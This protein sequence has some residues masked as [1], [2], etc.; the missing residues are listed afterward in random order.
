MSYK[1]DINSDDS[2]KNIDS[3]SNN[4]SNS[5]G[6]DVNKIRVIVQIKNR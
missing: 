1:N 5:N 4:T 6:Y 2:N 3:E